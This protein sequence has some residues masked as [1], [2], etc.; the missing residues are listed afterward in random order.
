MKNVVTGLRGMLAKFFV[1]MWW[2]S[3]VSLKGIT[4]VWNRGLFLKFVSQWAKGWLFMDSNCKNKLVDMKYS[5][6]NYK[7]SFEI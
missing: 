5:F 3:G 4:K 2:I 7:D 1:L 6:E